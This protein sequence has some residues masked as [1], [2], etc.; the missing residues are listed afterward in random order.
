MHKHKITFSIYGISHKTIFKKSGAMVYAYLRSF[1]VI[2]GAS[3]ALH[4]K[5]LL[6]IKKLGRRLYA[7]LETEVK[8][9]PH[10]LK[11]YLLEA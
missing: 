6:E 4:L 8:G 9:F 2:T 5:K 3:Y 11:K 1:P 10:S 7:C